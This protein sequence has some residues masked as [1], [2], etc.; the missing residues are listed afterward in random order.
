MALQQVL[1]ISSYAFQFSVFKGFLSV[2]LSVSLFLVPALG[3]LFLLF[4]CF[5][6]LL[7]ISS[8]LS[9]YIFFLYYSL[10]AS[11]FLNKTERE[12]LDGRGDRKELG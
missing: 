5:I 9:E 7:C 8:A 6:Q 11:L 12:Y 1:W 3:L 10:E 4:V 2:R